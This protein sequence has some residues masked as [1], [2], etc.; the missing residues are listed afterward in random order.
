V[1]RKQGLA[2]NLSLL[3]LVFPRGLPVLPQRTDWTG[4]DWTGLAGLHLGINTQQLQ[5]PLRL[6]SPPPPPMLNH[7][8]LETIAY[9]Q[10][11]NFVANLFICI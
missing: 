6:W 9:S 5:H 7:K 1:V 8:L 2:N 10:C 4:L 11:K 3:K